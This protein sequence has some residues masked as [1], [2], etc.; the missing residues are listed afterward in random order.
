[1]ATLQEL[2]AQREAIEREIE[3][4]KKRERADAI[5]R[6]R[7]LMAEYGLTL[8]DL[9]GKTT[10]SSGKSAGTTKVPPKYRNAAT[11]DTWSGRGLQPNWLKA[12]LASGRKLDE[13][14]V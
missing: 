3:L 14:K 9:G 10:G 13:F 2:L 12:A 7:S 8:A 6:V 1:M 4:T 11:G 5:A